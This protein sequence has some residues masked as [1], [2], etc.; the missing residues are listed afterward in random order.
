[1]YSY[2]PSDLSSPSQPLHAAF[3]LS[4]PSP[5]TNLN[6]N[7]PTESASTT[8]QDLILSFHPNSNMCLIW[9]ISG[10]CGHHLRDEP[11][12][13]FRKREDP[14]TTCHNHVM[15]SWEDGKCPACVAKEKSASNLAKKE[16]AGKRRNGCC[17]QRGRVGS[18]S[19]FL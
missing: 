8:Q 13:C 17:E 3:L 10:S 11:H 1:M 19:G 7:Y 6:L 12:P 16:S 15:E 14:D 4:S 9:K 2:P 18:G 5:R